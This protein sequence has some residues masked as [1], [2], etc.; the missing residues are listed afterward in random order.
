MSLPI[1]VVELMSYF[2]VIDGYTLLLFMN[3]HIF[4][5]DPHHLPT[6]LFLHFSTFIELGILVNLVLF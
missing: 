4:A 3:R 2:R 6:R 5:S 1:S